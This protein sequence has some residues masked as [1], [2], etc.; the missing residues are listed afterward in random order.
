MKH[1]A[2]AFPVGQAVHRPAAFLLG[3]KL[4]GKVQSLRIP[5]PHSRGVALVAWADG[6]STEEPVGDLAH[7]S[8]P[9]PAKVLSFRERV[10]A[11]FAR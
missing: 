3:E 10:Q 1:L 2:S 4:D 9:R 6:S 11:F 8:H 5:G 7:G